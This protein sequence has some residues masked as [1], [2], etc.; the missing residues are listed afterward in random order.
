MKEEVL[1]MIFYGDT[2][3]S[4][5]KSI[6]EQRLPDTED[7]EAQLKNGLYALSKGTISLDE[8]IRKFEETCDK[9]ATIKKPLGDADKVFQIS[10][11]LGDKYKEF[12]IV[13]LSKP[14]YLSFNQFI[15]SLQNFEWVYLT[16]ERQQLNHN[17]AFF[18]Q[19][20]RGKGHRGGITMA[21][22]EKMSKKLLQP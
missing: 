2:T 22:K 7:N 3:Y 17:Q 20:G 1:S 16:E 6:Q 14:P 8:Y 12:R 13:V 15:M 11:G 18:R 4:I 9:L 10:Y 5:W 21:Q 19:R